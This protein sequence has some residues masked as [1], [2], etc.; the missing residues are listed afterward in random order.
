MKPTTY[1]VEHY[2]LYRDGRWSTAAER[3]MS[4]TEEKAVVLGREALAERFRTIS[5]FECL[6][7]LYHIA[8]VEVDHED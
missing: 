1:R 8:E 5:S 4:F 6:G 3:V 2:I 7:P